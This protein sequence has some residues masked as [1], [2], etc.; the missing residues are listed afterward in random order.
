VLARLD[1]LDGVERSYANR[2][3]TLIRLTLRPGAD[4]DRVTADAAK[5]L[6]EED[7]ERLGETPDGEEWRDVSHIRELSAIERRT[8]LL[9]ALLVLALAGAAVGLAVV[10]W[11]RRRRTV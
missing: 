6:G 11:R 7:V 9:R 5:T 2:T 8:L 3:G 4:A 10:W 1:R